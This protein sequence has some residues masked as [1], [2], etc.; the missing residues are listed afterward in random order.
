MIKF[1]SSIIILV[2]SLAFAFLY[3]RPEYDRTQSSLADL[4]ILNN[5]LES[6][7]KMK[8]LVIQIRDSLAS[9]DP[10]DTERASVFLP[11]MIDEIRFANNLQSI[12]AK[13][14]I[15]LIDIKV[16]EGEKEKISVSGAVSADGEG[17]L[18]NRPSR[19]LDTKKAVNQDTQKPTESDSEKKYVTTKVSF[20]L[21]T[22][23]EKF[24][25]LLGE[26]ERSLEIIN[27]TSLSFQ[28]H[29]EGSDT[30][31]TKNTPKGDLLYK[32]TVEIETYSLK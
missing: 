22:T 27:V 8:E 12:G 4:K 20:S 23:Y 10:V 6:T 9:I 5:T 16:G 25:V 29:K 11:E 26:L 31:G 14:G 15:A 19:S 28:E 1:I 13:N 3:V 17:F 2:L 30:D 18:L 32:Y 21:S 24:L 7:E